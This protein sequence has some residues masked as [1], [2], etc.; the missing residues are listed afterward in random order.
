MW[1]HR[2][3]STSAGS[4]LRRLHSIGDV[5]YGDG[6]NRS[7]DPANRGRST[8]NST[9]DASTVDSIPANPLEDSVDSIPANPLEDSVDSIPAN[10][11]EEAKRIAKDT[12]TTFS[13]HSLGT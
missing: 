6:D 10:P 4:H 7:Y 13:V 5:I 1:R 8:E 9:F 11:L 12:V 3:S 2:D